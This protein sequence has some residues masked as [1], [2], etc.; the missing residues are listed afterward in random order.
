MY[1]NMRKMLAV[2]RTAAADV[3]NPSRAFPVYNGSLGPFEMSETGE[4]VST[5]KD[6]VAYFQQ[7]SSSVH[8]FQKGRN[9]A[10]YMLEVIG[11]GTAAAETA[12]DFVDLYTTSSMHSQI[13]QV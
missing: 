2:L 1:A 10:E 12:V 13:I 8:R 5:A 4:R 7:S 9:P 6:L 11:G 3:P